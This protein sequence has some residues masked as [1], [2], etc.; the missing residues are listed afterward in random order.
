MEALH[1]EKVGTYTIKIFRDEFPMDPRRDFEPLGTFITWTRRYRSPDENPFET[2][3]E[4]Q[5]YVR[6]EEI[7]EEYII[8]VYV[9]IHGGITF[10]TTPFSDPW[11]SGQAGYIYMEPEAAERS[12]DGD[13]ERVRKCLEAEVEEYSDWCEGRVYG[14]VIEDED[15][16]NVDSC[17]GFIGD[18][19]GYC[20]EEA[21]R[22][23]EWYVERDRKE[24]A[25]L[26]EFMSTVWAD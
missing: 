20:L 2:P 21:R 6:E 3:E 9:Y 5:Q 10:R 7:P 24:E 18:Y 13:T 23:A 15:G 1:E 14:F 16:E 22:K 25:E 17:W 8:S 11:D 4:F 12:F 26:E 19:D